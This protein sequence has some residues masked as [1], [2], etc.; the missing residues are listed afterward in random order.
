M[1][2]NTNI[3][4]DDIQYV[5]K[6]VPYTHRHYSNVY[7]NVS[8]T[9]TYINVNII[10]LMGKNGVVWYEEADNS[11]RESNQIKIRLV[12]I[13]CACVFFFIYT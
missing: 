10:K 3:L 6:N 13:W 2:T 8:P 7:I 11:T 9:N 12:F 4:K 1:V 5:Q